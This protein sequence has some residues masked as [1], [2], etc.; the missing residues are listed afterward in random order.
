MRGWRD[1]NWVG[2]FSS[3]NHMNKNEKRIKSQVA[4]A[5]KAGEATFTFQRPADGYHNYRTGTFAA[6]TVPIHKRGQNGV[7][8]TGFKRQ[9]GPMQMRILHSTNEDGRKSSLT[10]HEKR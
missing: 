7:V 6:I 10:V 4:T 2:H 1:T 8:S 9:H 3:V 5:R